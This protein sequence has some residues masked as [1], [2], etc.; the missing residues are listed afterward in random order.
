MNRKLLIVTG[1]IIAGFMVAGSLMAF[2][3]KVQQQI[4]ETSVW[5][6]KLKDG[7]WMQVGPVTIPCHIE[8]GDMIVPDYWP[9]PGL[10]FPDPDDLADP[11]VIV[12]I[13]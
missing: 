10:E 4:Q 7:T 6:F 8:N 11:D 2:T 13:A 1:F 5:F 12:R 9:P 3:A